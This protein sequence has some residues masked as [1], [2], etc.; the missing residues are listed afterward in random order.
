MGLGDGE[1]IR[2][3]LSIPRSWEWRGEREFNRSLQD[4]AWLFTGVAGFPCVCQNVGGR[5]PIPADLRHRAMF[6]I[7]PLV[8]EQI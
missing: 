8:I 3:C 4:V 5:I 6:L 7:I 1:T 2:T